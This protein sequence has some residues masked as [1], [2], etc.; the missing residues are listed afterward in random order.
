MAA[1]KLNAGS[2]SSYT[3]SMAEDME[4]AL[5]AL[6]AE[7]HMSALPASDPD[8]QMMFLAIARGVI[9]HL[10]DHEK[11]FAISFTIDTST[12]TIKTIN[13]HPDIGVEGS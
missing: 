12:H 2:F 5:H 13:T 4:K 3:G 10:A 1:D 7:K 11:A 8:R 9:K 6:R